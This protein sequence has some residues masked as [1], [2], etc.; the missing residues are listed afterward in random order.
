M[1]AGL[2]AA[3]KDGA[4]GIR[5]LVRLAGG[6]CLELPMSEQGPPAAA[7]MGSSGRR[8][9]VL[10]QSDTPSERAWAAKHTASGTPVQRR[11]SLIMALV[12]QALDS[13]SDVIFLSE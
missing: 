11:S 4:A 2:V 8:L 5:T 10:G 7:Q 1:H 6:V 3:E 9:L 13:R 12:R